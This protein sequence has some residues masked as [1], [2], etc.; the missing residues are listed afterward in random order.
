MHTTRRTRSL[1]VLAATTLALSACGGGGDDDSATEKSSSSTTQSESS[2]ETA[3]SEESA[4]SEEG[5]GESAA[6]GGS[7]VTATQSGVSFQVPD[8]WEGVDPQKLLNSGETPKALKDMAEAQGMEPDAFLQQISQS[9]D[10]MVVG[11]TKNDFADNVNVIRQPA[12][13]STAASKAQLEQI[14]ASVSGTEK[15]DT[16]L[17][18]AQDTTYTLPA[19]GTTVH[20]RSLAVPTADGAVAITVSSS[21]AA[22]ADKVA[23]QILESIDKA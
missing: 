21:D 23:T 4:A 10:L 13:P 15:V 7:K 18:A 9:L 12:M 22:E 5:S 17:G 6:S 2:Q 11:P 3:A 19:Q 16:A 8:G 1:A 20:G 14:G